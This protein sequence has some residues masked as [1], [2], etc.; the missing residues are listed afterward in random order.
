MDIK[1]VEDIKRMGAKFRN[2]IIKIEK[3]KGLSRE[4][5]L[6]SISFALIL[7]Y[8]KFEDGY[9]D[10]D[11][12]IDPEKGTLKVFAYKEVVES[13]EDSKLEISLKDAKRKDKEATE[14]DMI[15]VELK[16]PKEFEDVAVATSKQVILD[17][18]REVEFV[19]AIAE[20]EKERGIPKDLLFESI[21]SAILSAYKKNYYGKS[22]NAHVHL[23]RETGQ[24]HIITQKIVVEEVMDVNTE[25]SLAE[26][27]E[28][29]EGYQVD[30][31][32]EY[33]HLPA[34]EF[35]RIAAQ[36]AKQVV[37]QRIREAERGIVYDD[38]INKK[39]TM[40]TG[41][42]SRI[43]N[44]TIFVSIGKTEG[45]LPASEQVYNERFSVGDRIKVF[46]V[47]VK[48]TGKGPQIFL[49]RTHHDLVKA[50]FEFEVPEIEDGF[51]EIKSVARE[52]GSR[53]KIAV[54]TKSENIDPIGA[55][56]GSRG[57]RVQNIV[58]EIFG[59][60]IDIILWSDDNRELV[61]S[62]LSPAEVTDVIVDE[63]DNSTLVIVPDSQLSLAIGKEGQNV[64]LAARLCG[65]KI[66]IKSESQYNEMNNP[67]EVESEETEVEE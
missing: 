55:C 18:L 58:D 19:E 41:T 20:L 54:Y 45:I 59:E 9:G 34:E 33:N 8:K 64:R 38:F 43:R 29:H 15:P 50:L 67:T 56:V 2:A 31:I 22:A 51:V 11:V 61:K 24:I 60:K 53:T 40:V 13:V 46:I 10:I 36:T 44:N 66:D 26:A 25:I 63:T 57:A 5:L 12:A 7:E 39:N 1:F 49:S 30:D 37:V 52:P 17:R 6:D 27:Q 3:E 4:M 35:G 62:V 32:I 47:D 65:F 42:V 21:E 48:N 28:I 14:G 23:D 16:Y